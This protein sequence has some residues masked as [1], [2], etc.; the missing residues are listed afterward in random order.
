MQPNSLPLATSED[1]RLLANISRE[2]LGT[3]SG[4]ERVARINALADALD[5]LHATPEI[6][7][8]MDAVRRNIDTTRDDDKVIYVFR[9]DLET[10]LSALYH[11]LPATPEKT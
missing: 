5:H 11:L 9:G 6:R 8:V 7:E 2:D 3:G 1:L 4:Y 10:L